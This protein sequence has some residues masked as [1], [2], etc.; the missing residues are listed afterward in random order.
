MGPVDAHNKPDSGTSHHTSPITHSPLFTHHLIILHTRHT[1]S[2]MVPSHYLRYASAA[3][4]VLIALFDLSP[5]TLGLVFPA[6]L[7]HQLHR[8]ASQFLTTR[9]Q[10]HTT[11]DS[12]VG[13]FVPL[14]SHGN[15]GCKIPLDHGIGLSSL[16]SQQFSSDDDYRNSKNP[17]LSRLC[18]LLLGSNGNDLLRFDS[19]APDEVRGIYLNRPVQRKEC[20]LKLPLDMCL[21]D[22][23]PPA[24]LSFSST[25]EE[26]SDNKW[27]T[28]LAA[29]WMDV[30]LQCSKN[31]ESGSS[32]EDSFLQVH[33]LW[34]SL[35][36]DPAFLK[37]S[38]PIHWSE[39]VV[40]NARSTNLEMAVDAAYFV[41]ADAIQALVESINSSSKYANIMTKEEFINLAERAL[42]V[43]QTRSCRIERENGEYSRVLAPIF[44]FINHG[45]RMK[46][47]DNSNPRNNGI[48][49]AWFV[50]EGDDLVVR[51]LYDL[52]QDE[53]I[54][55]DYGASSRPAWKCLLS[56]GF[57]PQY[58]YK[59][60]TEDDVAEV[61]MMG[62]RYE[63]TTGAIPVDMVVEAARVTAI[64][65]HPIFSNN[66]VSPPATVGVALTPEVAT[67]IAD[68]CEE[69]GFFLLLEPDLDPYQDFDEAEAVKLAPSEILS[70]RLAASLRWSQHKVLMACAAGLRRFV[71]EEEHQEMLQ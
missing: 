27:A 19:A 64:D 10:L 35:L 21:N 50:R 36:P 12:S 17:S 15:E 65:V 51:A 49:N 71:T 46:N 39:E 42:D 66:S 6:R 33:K 14:T 20:L 8:H 2:K 62:Q 34:L 13:T 32:A 40:A 44:D 60:S 53:E 9:R 67:R 7:I 16:S 48:A 25:T 68:R 28:R 23:H 22:Q 61:Y 56:Y 31:N 29:S 54:L 26:S 55:I 41:R 45:P 57:I 5:T 43:V 11:V 24:W 4:V 47:D 37:A 63:V 59:T 18:C 52:H 3:L 30:Y 38:L 1:L 58:N 70:H 69:V